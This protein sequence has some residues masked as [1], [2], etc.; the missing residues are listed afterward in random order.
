MDT[1][2]TPFA[3][4]H[5]KD[6]ERYY[7]L[8]WFKFV[9][10]NILFL[11]F[12]VAAF[13]QG[14]VDKV[15]SKDPDLAWFSTLLTF[16]V[17]T[18]Y[19]TLI[20]LVFLGGLVLSVYKV[21]ATSREINFLK[22][23]EAPDFSRVAEYLSSVRGVNSG[24]RQNCFQFLWERWFSRLTIIKFLANQLMLLGLLGTV[25]GFIIALSGVKP[26]AASD[27]SG[28]RPM[29]STLINGMSI[30]LF[31]TVAGAVLGGLWLK[32]NYHV[33][34]VGSIDFLTLLGE[35]AERV[36]NG[37]DVDYPYSDVNVTRDVDAGADVTEGSEAEHT[38]DGGGDK[39]G[40]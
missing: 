15:F 31:T 10:L 35:R 19:V 33:L 9:L 14:W 5:K 7:Y 25:L 37:R 21:F 1:A 39:S 20:S 16:D 40:T 3:L 11:T 29:I 32:W 38:G 12:F 24:S 23:R 34:Y 30:A 2:R 13:F 28:I 17:Q 18:S 8:L 26:D 27:V 6:P 22:M 36:A 4:L